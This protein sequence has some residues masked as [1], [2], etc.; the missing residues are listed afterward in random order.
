MPSWPARLHLGSPPSDR[1]SPVTKS[2]ALRS[3]PHERQQHEGSCQG[4]PLHGV[5]LLASQRPSQANSRQRPQHGR[6][7]SHPFV[8]TVGSQHEQTVGLCTLDD[9][10]PGP[11]DPQLS[12]PGLASKEQMSSAHS[13]P[14]LVGEKDLVTG[15]CSTC[16]SL[17]RWPRRLD[18]FRCTVCLMVNDLKVSSGFP[19]E[20]RSGEAP[21]HNRTPSNTGA[22]GRG[23][24][25]P[26]LNELFPY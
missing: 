5:P 12:F 2:G 22:L 13:P 14:P 24:V 20:G 17:V 4:P 6:S 25:L 11:N 19:L 21:I 8:T 23:M 7:H 3:P 9:S 18:V 15:R 26:S 1:P 10:M 16:D